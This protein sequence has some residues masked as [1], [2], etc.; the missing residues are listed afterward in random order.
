MKPSLQKLAAAA[1]I[2]TLGLTGCSTAKEVLAVGEAAEKNPGP[3]PEAFALYEA[4][5]MVEFRGEE[6]Y[7]NVGFTAEIDKVRSLCRYVGDSPISADLTLDI[8]FG[9]GPA[10][11]ESSATYQYF[12]AVTRKNIDV[13]EKQVF[14]I[15]IDFPVGENVVRATENVGEII[16]PRANDTTSGANFEIIVG[17]ELT[18]EQIAFNAD[19]KRF[20]V[21]AG[22]N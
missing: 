8:S 5:R 4:S 7:N 2:V 12:V 3:C 1:L 14:P 13:I 15:T 18:P 19:G 16:I 21:S 6:A 22:Q 10:A 17:F 9:R 20:R 11:Q